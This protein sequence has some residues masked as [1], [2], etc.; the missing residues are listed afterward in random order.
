MEL[1]SSVWSLGPVCQEQ[2]I[3]SV[4]ASSSSEDGVR[5]LRILSL[6]SAPA[7]LSCYC[8]PLQHTQSLASESPRA[9]ATGRARENPSFKIVD[10]RDTQVSILNF[11]H[12]GPPTPLR[13]PRSHRLLDYSLHGRRS[14]APPRYARSPTRL[15]RFQHRSDG[16]VQAPVV[17]CGTH[18]ALIP[19]AQGS[20][21]RVIRQQCS[22][23]AAAA[24]SGVLRLRL[25]AAGTV[26]V[27]ST[28]GQTPST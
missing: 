17:S 23:L 8:L 16:P 13:H 2:R 5:H 15:V 28:A 20:H 22:A 26:G 19:L 12:V 25:V 24:A 3:S 10:A 27:C 14:R 6:L 18:P 21:S 1:C 7:P 9:D 4:R 11:L